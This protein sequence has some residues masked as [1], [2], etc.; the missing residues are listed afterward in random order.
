MQ[1]REQKLA[2]L[3]PHGAK[4]KIAAKL[5]ISRQ[6]VGDA[7]RRAKPGNRVVIEALRMARESGAL[8]AALDLNSLQGSH[9]A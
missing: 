8:T 3:L 6:A 1:E 9:P 4:A 2:D 5:N 7:L